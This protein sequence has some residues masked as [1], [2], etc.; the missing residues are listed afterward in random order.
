MGS[1]SGITASTKAE[2]R[3]DAAAVFYVSFGLAWTII[4]FGAMFYLWRK[5]HLP[6]LAIR[7]LPLTFASVICL[8]LYWMLVQVC[9]VIGPI[10]P[11]VGEYWVMGTWLPWGISLFYAANAQLLH[12]AKVQKR[13]AH[14]QNV[15]ES[16]IMEESTN[17]SQ[18]S[19]SWWRTRYQRFMQKSYASRVW[20]LTSIAMIVQFLLTLLMYLISRKYH[21]SWGIPGTEVHGTAMERK[22]EQGRGWEWWPGVAVQVFWSWV[23]AP[24]VLWRSRHIR[25]THGWRL[26]TIA[27]CVSG[28]PATPM[29]LIALNVPGMEPCNHYFI[30]PQWIALSI[31]FIE[32][33]TVFVPVWEVKKHQ[34]LQEETLDAIAQWESKGQ[35]N[36]SLSEFSGSTDVVSPMSDSFKKAPSCEIAL[37]DLF[38]KSNES[39][40][41]SLYTMTALNRTLAHD[42]EPLRIFSALRDF[43]G[44]NIAFL[45]SVASWD[46]LWSSHPSVGSSNSGNGAVIADDLFRRTMF[47]HA[48]CIY[49]RFVSQAHADVPVNIVGGHRERLDQV[50]GPAAQVLFGEGRGESY[51]DMPFEY[52]FGSPAEK[53]AVHVSSKVNDVVAQRVQWWGDIPDEFDANVFRDAER[54]V[55]YLVLTNTWP[56]YVK[57][58]IELRRKESKPIRQQRRGWW[59]RR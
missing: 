25:D 51:S 47:K 17:K 6:S 23:V 28:M 26:Q 19:K 49:A 53:Q 30:P 5:R 46:A 16:T 24:V 39:S 14:N 48:V 33:F 54:S 20:I 40:P 2:P 43:S 38:R 29:W 55:K 44:E 35:K 21:A 31:W 42:P 7:G 57:E 41:E 10:E 4:L 37:D 27:C 3:L 9:I 15:S 36:V 1:E 8:H 11:E 59:F 34:G 50:F 22:V 58:M 18:R 12:V 13:F 45:T 52:L 56:K 32:I